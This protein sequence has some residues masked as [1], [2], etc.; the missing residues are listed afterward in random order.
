MPIN[1]QLRD[2]LL[3][4]IYQG[5]ITTAD[6]QG[7]AIKLSEYEASLEITPDRITDLTDACMFN[8]DADWLR[9]FAASRVQATL[10]NKVK[11]AIVAP[12]PDQYGLARMF[13]TSNENPLIDI[14]L[15]R[16]AASAYRWLGHS[17]RPA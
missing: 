8:I 11:S 12:K 13:Q 14:Q 7:A 9:R 4:L 16:D 1:F 2:G 15:F 10:R 5:D 6:M 3:E 17:A